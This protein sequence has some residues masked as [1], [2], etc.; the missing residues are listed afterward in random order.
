LAIL[1][2]LF[3]FLPLKNFY[4]FFA[5]LSNHFILSLPDEGYLT[6]SL[7]DEGYFTLSLPDE[8]YFT[9]SL[10]DEGYFT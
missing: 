6:L 9:L 5:W 7:P 2:R 10:P 1:Y 8:G 3:G 4:S